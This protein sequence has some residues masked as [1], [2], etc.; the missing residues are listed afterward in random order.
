MKLK[1]LLLCLLVCLP[2]NVSAGKIKPEVKPYDTPW[3]VLFIGNSF[4]YYNNGI[5]NHVGGLVRGAGAWKKGQHRFRLSSLSGGAFYEQNIQPLLAPKKPWDW[6]ILQAHSQEPINKYAEEFKKNAKKLTQQIQK[7]GAKAALFMTWG[8]ENQP[9]M[10]EELAS[11]YTELG[12]KLDILVVPVGLAFSRIQERH[13]KIRLYVPDVLGVDENS[14]L[15]YKK[16]IKHPS[17][18]GTY[19][20]AC[21]FYSVFYNRT[22]SG[23]V[24]RS[25]LGQDTASILQNEAWQVVQDFYAD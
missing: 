19:L 15:T 2:F 14:Q 22:P 5:Q 13:P 18:E 17:P 7:S 3:R 10:A 20:A 21:V 6:V 12:N 16:A 11:A 25:S 4:S 23:N 9:E 1:V 8:Y 24:Y